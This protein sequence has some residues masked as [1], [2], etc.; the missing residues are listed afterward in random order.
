MRFLVIPLILSTLITVIHG[1]GKTVPKGKPGSSGN[2]T[3]DADEDQKVA[4]DISSNISTTVTPTVGFPT[5]PPETKPASKMSE[6]N[7]IKLTGEREISV[8]DPDFFR[9]MVQPM[10][11]RKSNIRTRLSMYFLRKIKVF[12]F[13]TLL[14][15]VR[16]GKEQA[17]LKL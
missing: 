2:S 4:A 14:L 15:I 7:W 9:D 17:V 16:G 13:L 1:G 11:D 8:S 6:R 3:K 10:A 12:N 5:P